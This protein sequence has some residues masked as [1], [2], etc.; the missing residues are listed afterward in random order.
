MCS[1][2]DTDLEIRIQAAITWFKINPK[3]PTL[4]GAAK[5]YNV[6]CSTLNAWFN[7]RQTCR[8]AQQPRFLLLPAKENTLEELVLSMADLGFPIRPSQIRL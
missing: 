5:R 8:A 1:V 3:V 2:D 7:G 6:P 4:R